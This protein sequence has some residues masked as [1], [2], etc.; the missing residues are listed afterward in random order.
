MINFSKTIEKFDIRDAI[1]EILEI[2]DDK[3]K[4]KNIEFETHFDGFNNYSI[5]SDSKRIQQVFLNILSNAV[6]FTDRNGHITIK[7]ELL[8]SQGKDFIKISVKDTGIGIK[9]RN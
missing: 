4:M 6:K 3:I 8:R 5:C 9:K 7:V 1:K 2:Q